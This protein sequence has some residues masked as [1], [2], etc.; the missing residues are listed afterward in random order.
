MTR[1]RIGPAYNEVSDEILAKIVKIMGGSTAAGE[2]LDELRERRE[3]GED[4]VCY[5]VPGC[6]MY[7]VGPRKSSIGRAPR[8]ER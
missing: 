5:R 8:R 3:C 1:R 4:A 7:F 2:V 6:P